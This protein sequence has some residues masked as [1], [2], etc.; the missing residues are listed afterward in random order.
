MISVDQWRAAIGCRLDRGIKKR[1]RPVGRKSLPVLLC[2][3]AILSLHSVREIRVVM[4]LM[5]CCVLFQTVQL[6]QDHA[7]LKPC[8]SVYDGYTC[9][10][11]TFEVAVTNVQECFREC[12]RR[13][14]PCHTQSHHA[15]DVGRSNTLLLR[16]GDVEQNPG[17]SGSE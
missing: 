12:G 3:L 4:T 5:H 14:L 2:L 8:S 13:F 1:G 10:S 7:W 15:V 11:P 17:P 6:A 9:C 16:C